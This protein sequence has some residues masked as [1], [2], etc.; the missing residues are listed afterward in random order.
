MKHLDI[1]EK[2]NE[3][4]DNLSGYAADSILQLSITRDILIEKNK[5]LRQILQEVYEDCRAGDGELQDET[6]ERV[7]KYFEP[8]FEGE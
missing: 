2:L 8:E 6:W 4:G 3:R 7:I 5:E 1:A